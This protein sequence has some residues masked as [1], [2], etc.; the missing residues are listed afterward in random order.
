MKQ[1]VFYAIEDEKHMQQLQRRTRVR[2]PDKDKERVRRQI[3][4]RQL[5]R[6]E[7]TQ[8]SRIREDRT[9]KTRKK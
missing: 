9:G 6:L 8:D 1:Q 4:M 2:K 5:L 3:E 7:L